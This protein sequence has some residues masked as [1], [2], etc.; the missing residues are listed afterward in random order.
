VTADYTYRWASLHGVF[1]NLKREPGEGNEEAIQPTW[2]GATQTDITQRDRKSFSGLLTLTPTASFG[3]TLSAMSQ[4]NSF[5]ES[6]TGL[7]DQSFSQF[8]VDL[9]YAPNARFNAYGGYSYE[10][11]KFDM[12][13]AYIPRGTTVAPNYD[14]TKDPNYWANATDDKIDTFRAGFQWTI[15]PERFD[16]NV[17]VDY[18]KPRNASDYTFVPGGA[19]EANGVWPA[20]A[21]TGFTSSTFNG[22]PLVSKNFLIAKVRLSYKLDKNLTASLMWWKQKFD[23]VDWQNDASLQP[24]MGRTDPG[25]NRWFFLGAQVPSYDADIFRV[26]VTYK[27]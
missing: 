2:Q 17:D 24:Y 4:T 1:T 12:A 27:F 18:T 11:Y 10:Q 7:L 8:G 3:V 5:P 15:R 19:G 21:V 9:T 22:F 13:A 26:S 23:N 14:P 6:V 20:T 25:S 16:L